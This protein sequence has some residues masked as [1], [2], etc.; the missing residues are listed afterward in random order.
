MK[1]RAN[2]RPG[3]TSQLSERWSDPDRLFHNFRTLKSVDRPSIDGFSESKISEVSSKFLGKSVQNRSKA[4]ASNLFKMRLNLMIL[5]QKRVNLSQ[6][7]E[8]L[9]IPILKGVL[10]FC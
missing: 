2:S 5:L 1:N 3:F 4:S 8:K 6:S 9:E 7:N 10:R